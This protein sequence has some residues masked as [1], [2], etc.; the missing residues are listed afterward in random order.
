MQYQD[1]KP[2]AFSD[3]GNDWRN[4]TSAFDGDLST[5]ADNQPDQTLPQNLD[6]SG[7]TIALSAN[8]AIFGVRLTLK[9]GTSGFV[10][11]FWEV[12]LINGATNRRL[13]T[14]IVTVTD[15]TTFEWEVLAN[16]KT[17]DGLWTKADFESMVLR[18]GPVFQ[19]TGA[20]TVL[21]KIYDLSYRVFTYNTQTQSLLTVYSTP[22]LDGDITDNPPVDGLGDTVDNTFAN[23]WVGDR[24][25]NGSWWG[26]VSFPITGLPANAV[27]DDVQMDFSLDLSYGDGL[28]GDD[29]IP[30]GLGSCKVDHVDFGTTL[31]PSDYQITPLTGDI[32]ILVLQEEFL[33]GYYD[34]AEPQTWRWRGIDTLPLYIQN[35][36]NAGRHQWAF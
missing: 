29:Q 15:P 34:F 35:D 13:W 27:I 3:P 16:I 25:T 11:D 33:Q 26:F 18:I 12:K 14:G 5:F 4:E 20:D 17:E 21:I 23:F 32:G 7:Q 19:K 2:T 31:D 30:H 6:F 8:E 1:V 9:L 28:A 36:Y 24:S 22:A 10:N